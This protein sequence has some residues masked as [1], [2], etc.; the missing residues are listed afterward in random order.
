MVITWGHRH[1]RMDI[2]KAMSNEWERERATGRGQQFNVAFQS[3][4]IND[5]IL[6][7]D[8][9][10]MQKNDR[11]P[12]FFNFYCQKLYKNFLQVGKLAGL[13]QFLHFVCKAYESYV[14][15]HLQPAELLQR[16]RCKKL[17]KQINPFNW[18]WAGRTSMFSLLFIY[19]LSNALFRINCIHILLIPIP[20]GKTGWIK[21]WIW[22]A[23][24]ICSN[25]HR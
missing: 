18:K 24:I 8:I 9:V 21:D 14:Q 15:C 10:L 17:G 3:L 7:Y 23:H 5:Q 12:S 22:P 19:Y 1:G 13:Q 25:F 16:W 4:L 11:H 20:G 6:Q 2:G